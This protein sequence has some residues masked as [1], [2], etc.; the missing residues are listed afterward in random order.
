[1]KFL[2]S[3]FG[4]S[5]EK[6]EDKADEL[7]LDFEYRD[8]AYYYQQALDSLDAEEHESRGRLQK[9]LREVRRKAFAQLLEDATEFLRRNAPELAHERL[10][11]AANFADDTPS[12][13]EVERRQEELAALLGDEPPPVETPET[14]TGTEDDLFELALSGYE[15]GDRERALG[16]GE[17]FRL[18][19]E[20]CQEERWPEALA[21]LEE[22]LDSHPDEPVALELAGTVAEFSGDEDRAMQ[23]LNRVQ[24]VE[25]FRPAT[26]QGLVSLHRKAERTSEVRTL[27]SKAVSS[28]SVHSNLSEPW[29]QI[30]LDY[31][32]TLSE[33]GHHN[34]AASTILALTGVKKA[35]RASLF[36]N[37]AG[38]MEREG[39]DEDCREA[40]EAAV[41]AAPRQP[42][43]M[44][45]LS[46]FLVKH[47]VEFDA[48]L[49]LMVGANEVET[50]G[51]GAG[52]LGGG[53]SKAI[54]SPNRA[55]Y[56]YKIA[57]I[58]FLKGDDREAERIITTALAVSRDPD[59]TS[60]LEGLRDELKEEQAA[61]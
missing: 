23:F 46:D 35:D 6:H 26:V 29:I 22:V 60:A 2:K 19:Y 57:R 54:Q 31:A 18:A 49:K 32:L 38:V 10:E 15:S 42:I 45:R 14:V 20:A 11:I 43:Y 4:G 9:K 21:R 5:A 58:Y 41:A 8:A 48:A 55:R 3:L 50:T 36:F 61:E 27:L 52:M 53:A 44:E 39:R 59:V 33:D 25:P 17:P 13:E 16:M 37:L 24:E 28:N 12:R 34:K 1:M 56:L 51:G 30:H 7:R 40:L 47:R